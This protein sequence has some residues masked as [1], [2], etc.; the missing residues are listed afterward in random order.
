MR[1]FKQ[2]GVDAWIIQSKHAMVCKILKD[3]YLSSLKFMS[4]T[5]S[6][7]L[8]ILTMT[9]IMKFVSGVA[10]IFVTWDVIWNLVTTTFLYNLH[11]VRMICMCLYKHVRWQSSDID[12]SWIFKHPGVLLF[13][14]K[15]AE[16]SK[17]HLLFCL[18]PQLNRTGVNLLKLVVCLMM[19]IF[20]PI[21]S[22][23]MASK[24]L[25]GIY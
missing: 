4:K 14:W 5:I 22:L 1:E 13:L 19:Y 10:F 21:V 2:N 12:G 15:L 25:V 7:F 6:P 16:R 9:H 11:M 24:I 18:I 23:P 8:I 20:M 3:N 17:Q